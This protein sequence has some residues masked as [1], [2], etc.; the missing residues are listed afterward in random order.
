MPFGSAKLQINN[1][2]QMRSIGISRCI[3]EIS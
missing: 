2:V 3:W 1:V